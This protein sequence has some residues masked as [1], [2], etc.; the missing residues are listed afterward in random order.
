M[1]AIVYKTW[2]TFLAV[3]QGR[4]CLLWWQFFYSGWIIGI[5][6]YHQ[7][8]FWLPMVY[9]RVNQYKSIHSVN[10]IKKKY[11]YTLH[12]I[13]SLSF[14]LLIFFPLI[15]SVMIDSYEGF[16]K[17]CAAHPY[18]NLN[19]SCFACFHQWSTIG[20]QNNFGCLWYI[21]CIASDKFSVNYFIF[22]RN[23]QC[24]LVLHAETYCSYWF[25]Q[26]SATSTS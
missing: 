24:Y 15:T 5:D 9:Y 6:K 18:N 16:F 20:W 3:I 11:V 10:F 7:G 26:N 13:S 22:L 1:T 19:W 17:K 14:V 12:H 25:V 2:R 21:Q 8:S 4:N 23:S